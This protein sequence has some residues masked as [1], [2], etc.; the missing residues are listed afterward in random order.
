MSWIWRVDCRSIILSFKD[1]P[2]FVSAI[3]PQKNHSWRWDHSLMPEACETLCHASLHSKS[4]TSTKFP[5][6][7]ADRGRPLSSLLSTHWCYRFYS[8]TYRHM[9][10]SIFYAEIPVV[11]LEVECE[12]SLRVVEVRQVAP[13]CVL[14]L[15]K[16]QLTGVFKIKRVWSLAKSCKLFRQFEAWAVKRGDRT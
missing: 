3:L 11:G 4:P 8:A 7:E 9:F 1:R 14:N 6:V 12:I 5:A 10:C 13:L 16:L 2:I 15:M